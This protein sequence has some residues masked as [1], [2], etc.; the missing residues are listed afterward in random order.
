MA[1][2]R[3]KIKILPNQYVSESGILE[4]YATYTHPGKVD[5]DNI[6]PYC[7]YPLR[8]WLYKNPFSDEELPEG[9]FLDPRVIVIN[10]IPF[11]ARSDCEYKR[12][13]YKVADQVLEYKRYTQQQ[14]LENP[15]HHE[16]NVYRNEMQKNLWFIV[17]FA[18]KNTLANHPFVVN[19]CKEIQSETGDTLEVWAREHLKTTVISTCRQ[20][21]KVLNDQDKTIAIISATRPL[22]VSIL[23]GIRRILEDKFVTQCFPDILYADANREAWKWSE[24]PEGGLFVKRKNSNAKEPTFSA[25]GMVQGLPVGFHFTDLV[26][27][28]I[29]TQDL[30]AP[31]VME[32]IKELFDVALNLGSRKTQTT[33]IGTFYH[34]NDPLVYVAS[35]IDLD[36][37]LPLFPMR[38]K[39]ASD[40]GEEDGKP[41]F[42]T[43]KAYNQ[44]RAGI[45]YIFYCQ[46]LLNP[47]PRGSE[48][49]NYR[50]L[51]TVKKGQLP[52]N[53]Y[54]FMLIDG[55]GDKGKRNDHKKSDAWAMA[56]IGVEPHK[57]D[58]G[59]SRIFILDLVIKEM[60]LATAQ[61]AAV[62]MYCRNGRI[63]RLGI[64]KVAM[65]T[66]EIHIASALAARRKFVS[67]EMGNLQI[68]QPRGR[69]K[70]FRIESALALPLKHGK[71]HI[72]DTVEYES[73]DRLYTEMEKF[74]AYK[75][76][77]LDAISYVY[78]MIKEYRFGSQEFT[79][80]L[81]DRWDEAF[82]KAKRGRNM[83]GWIA[84]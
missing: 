67:V 77:G 3:K 16:L 78:D 35:K 34:H 11:Q 30:T 61:S 14:K 76:D 40:T 42:L 66:T 83:T 51:I 24:A 82:E 53:L 18:S 8:T 79:T 62:E 46:Q 69:Q 10:N 23:S 1:N 71:V 41:V 47:T 37:G 28:D 21:Q 4:E 26:F 72:L 5:D 45:K 55:A 2:Y 84:V 60:D 38:K 9:V 44:K 20:I 63:L 54:K 19:A 74:P 27:D 13:P 15:L 32:K 75:D 81:R 43:Q 52:E 39:S 64:E 48:K 73:R 36:S 7:E 50:H 22:A 68:M 33:V 58:A 25:W 6:H 59:L 65:S 70:A 49:L 57:D 29:I 31:D 80:V 17:Y 56:V 12:N